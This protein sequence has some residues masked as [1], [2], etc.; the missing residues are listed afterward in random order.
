MSRRLQ[1]VTVILFL[2]LVFSLALSFWILPDAGF[3]EQENRSLRTFPKFTWK[4]LASGEFSSEINDYFAD[5]FPLRDL[6]VGVKGCAETAL[7]KGENNGVLL[8]Q[9]GQLQTRLFDMLNADGSV[10]KNTDAYDPATVQKAIDGIN[11]AG[12]NLEI[13]FSVLLT[14]RNIDIAPNATAYPSQ[15][16]DALFSQLQEGIGE[17]V[18]YIETV[19]LLRQKGEA[20]EYVYYKTDHHWTTL[21][22]YYA[23]AEVMRSMGMESEILPMDSFEKKTVSTE[24]FGTA[25]SAGGMKFVRPDSIELWYQGNEAEFTVTADGKEL[26][27]LYSLSYLDKKD[28][29][30]VFLDGTHD[31]VTVTN[32]E[33]DRPVLLLLKDSFANSLAPFLAQ[34]FD[35]VLLNLSSRRD[36]TDLSAYAAE[37]HADRVLLV[38]TVENVVTADKLW[39]LR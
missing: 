6:F 18:D 15:L 39:K 7:G 12:E 5:Q 4:K 14:G 31:V 35:L 1:L 11:R 17:R 22:A 23:Y 21:G 8:G 3:S 30:S 20:G 16:S 38:Y 9:D 27:G 29:Y 19:P 28:K 34:H 26:G 37:Y 10:T 24:F 32:G 13:P 25:W 33:G 36:F 2:A